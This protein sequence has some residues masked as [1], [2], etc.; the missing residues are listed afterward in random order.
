MRSSR[1]EYPSSRKN[2]EVTALHCKRCKTITSGFY[3]EKEVLATLHLLFVLMWRL[4]FKGSF[5][6]RRNRGTKPMQWTLGQYIMLL[7]ETNST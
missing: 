1:S 2:P 3:P 5:L 6:R 4:P 7:R